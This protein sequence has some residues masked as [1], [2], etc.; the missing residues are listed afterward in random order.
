MLWLA[1]CCSHLLCTTAF[2][3]TA[4]TLLALSFSSIRGLKRITT[5]SSLLSSVLLPYDA[6]TG[7]CAG[8]LHC[9]QYLSGIFWFRVPAALVITNHIF[10]YLCG[11]TLGRTPLIKISPKKTLE[12]FVG[13][14]ICTVISGIIFWKLSRH[15]YYFICPFWHWYPCVVRRDCVHPVSVTD[16]RVPTSASF[17]GM[18]GTDIVS[19]PDIYFHVTALSTFAS[20]IAP[21][22]GFFASGLKRAFKVKD[23]GDTIPGHGGIVDLFDCQFL[24]G[25]FSYLYYDTFVATHGIA[26]DIVL[27]SALWTLIPRTKW[28]WPSPLSKYLVNNGLVHEKILECFA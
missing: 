3:P 7:C 16:H 18:L 13:A 17:Q 14:W 11:I 5:G 9:Q 10:A 6:I 27:Q 2:S 24:M 25:F 8:Q 26:F 22:G 19:F 12:G 1:I 15:F 20:L 21:F 23:F 4:S 28:C